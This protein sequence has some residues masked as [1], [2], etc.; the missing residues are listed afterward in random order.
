MPSL[1]IEANILI[2]PKDLEDDQ[3]RAAGILA[4]ERGS[5]FA[6]TTGNYKPDSEEQQRMGFQP[7]AERNRLD[8]LLAEIHAMLN[9][10]SVIPQTT[11]QN[12][13]KES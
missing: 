4:G 10:T 2:A 13:P 12:S 5:M 11:P 6:E 1:S 8:A 3:K 9:P 7:P